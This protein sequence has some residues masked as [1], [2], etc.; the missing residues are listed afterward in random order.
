MNDAI[1]A[2]S[3]RV[4]E[5]RPGGLYAKALVQALHVAIDAAVRA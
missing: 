3:Q 1:I 4:K 2:R 5:L